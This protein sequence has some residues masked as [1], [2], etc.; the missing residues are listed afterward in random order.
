[1]EVDYFAK[2]FINIQTN[3]VISS[4][5]EAH[6]IKINVGKDEKWTMHYTGLADIVS[7]RISEQ[8]AHAGSVKLADTTNGLPT[9]KI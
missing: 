3:I 6:I 7:N 9:L 5:P 4:L 8:S 2:T 1:M